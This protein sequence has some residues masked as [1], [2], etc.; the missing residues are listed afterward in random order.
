MVETPEKLGLFWYLGC[1]IATA[2]D[3][4]CGFGAF[5][6][7]VGGQRCVGFEKAAE[8]FG[9]VDADALGDLLDAFGGSGE[10]GGGLVHTGLIDVVVHCDA[11]HLLENRAQ[12]AFGVPGE[13]A[14]FVQAEDGLGRLRR[15]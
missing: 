9:V 7:F 14:D 12:I 1:W 5:A 6:V 2:W 8:I 10:Q 3:F 13:G 4:L 11:H 15:M